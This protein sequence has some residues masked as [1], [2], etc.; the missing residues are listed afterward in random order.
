MSW[1]GWHSTANAASEQYSGGLPASNGQTPPLRGHAGTARIHRSALVAARHQ[2]ATAA[3]VPWPSPRANTCR[4]RQV[5]WWCVGACRA[6]KAKRERFDSRSLHRSLSTKW[7][8]ELCANDSPHDGSS[9][10]QA[11]GW[12]TRISRPKHTSVYIAVA[13]HVRRAVRGT[14]VWRSCSR[15]RGTH[16]DMAF[17]THIADRHTTTEVPQRHWTFHARIRPNRQTILCNHVV[18]I[19]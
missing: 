8:T 14:G 3:R 13:S 1:H 7:T 5:R 10:S 9:G 11:C 18:D 12:R 16:V 15:R 4:R 6:R 17:L 19:S 2:N